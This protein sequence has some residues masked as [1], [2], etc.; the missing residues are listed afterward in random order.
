MSKIIAPLEL[1][2]AIIKPDVCRNP[3][4]LELLR[5]MVL[6]NNFY[7]VDTKVA[8][9]SRTEA[10]KFYIEHKDKFFFNRLVTFMSS[11]LLSAHIL[12]RENAIKHWRELM[13][14]THVYRAQYEAPLSLRARFGLTDTRNATHGSDSPD[15]ARREI[16][17]FFPN[18]NMEEFYK[19][20]EPYFR[21]NEVMFDP[22]H[23]VHKIKDA[24]AQ[25]I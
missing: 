10:E 20:Q 16:S 5:Q 24:K 8:Q 25:K 18:F 4:N 11:G 22:K 3:F 14:P 9:L 2:L 23:C 17:F 7:F 12:A 13:G 6:A 15:T 1:T 21:N 19:Y